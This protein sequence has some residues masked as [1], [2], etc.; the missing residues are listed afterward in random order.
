MRYLLLFLGVLGLLGLAQSSSA[1]SAAGGNIIQTNGYIIHTFTTV[2]TNS[3][4]VDAGGNIKVFGG[5]GSSYNLTPSNGRRGGIGRW[6][7]L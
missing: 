4:T 5:G 1:V 3:F 7:K 2:G 6:R